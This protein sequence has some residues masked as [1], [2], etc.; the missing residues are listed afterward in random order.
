MIR[1]KQAGRTGLFFLFI[2]VS[3]A[4]GQT[5]ILSDSLSWV[6]TGGPPGGLGY[7]IRYNYNDISI[8]YVTDAF[9]GVSI[10]T[11]RGTTWQPANTGIQAELGPTGDWIPIF[12]LTVD[13]LDPQ[14]VWAGTQWTG[15]IYKSIDGGYTWT[16]KDNGV[17]ILYDK[18]SFRG[19]TIDPRSSDIVYA[20]G[21]TTRN[22]P[23]PDE[24]GGQI[25]KTTDGGETW[26]LIWDGG[27]PSA[28][29][30]YLWTD[31]R[32]PDRLYV[33]TGIFDRPA[34]PN[35]TIPDLYDGLGVLKS[36]DG[37]M[38]WSAL[39]TANGLEMLHIGSLAMHPE[40]PDTL[41]AAA[42]HLLLSPATEYV[43]QQGYS[44]AGIYRTADGGDNWTRVLEPPLSRPNEAFSAVEYS[45][46]YP[47]IVYAGSEKAVYRS[48]DSGE[49]WELVSGGD[50][51]WG[52]PGV[53]ANWPIDFQCDPEDPYRLFANNYLGGNFL[54]TDGGQSWVNASQ[55]YTGAILMDVAV[56]PENPARVY[57]VGRT[58]IWRSDRSGDAWYGLRYGDGER[59][60]ASEWY[61]IE[62]DPSDPSHILAGGKNGIILLESFDGGM[63][64]DYRWSMFDMWPPEVVL[65]E[66]EN[67][68]PTTIVFA[69]SN[70][71]IVYA[72]GA[73]Q[74]SAQLHENAIIPAVG[75]LISQDGGHTWQVCSND[76][77]NDLAVFDLA[78]D[79][80]D[81]AA[82]YMAAEDGLYMT[83]DGG[84][85]WSHLQ[86]LQY[87]GM[88]RAVEV[89]P[90]D[91][92]H[93]L[94]AL[95]GFG[96]YVSTDGGQQ[97]QS[98]VAGLEPN[99]SIHDIVF[100]PTNPVIVYV[101]DYF[102][103]V[104]RSNDGG[105][106][107]TQM[108]NGLSTRSV[109][110]LAISGD[111]QHLYTATNGGGV[112]RLDLSGVAPT[113][114]ISSSQPPPHFELNQNYPNPFNAQTT[115]F[116]RIRSRSRVVIRIYDILGRRVETLVEKIEEPGRHTV[117]WNAGD[118]PS[119][120]YLCR[121]EAGD[122]SKTIRLLM[123][124]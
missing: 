52:P 85:S 96:V 42:G 49:T 77:V 114:V 56:D 92:D 95:E 6:R 12:C 18:L 22:D 20:M 23:N 14:I 5:T 124:K 35:D 1:M 115:I 60:A 80:T 38:T 11:D 82:V 19:F 4:I 93:I 99:G 116:Y 94:A 75:L 63:N 91:A 9:S 81:A 51:G 87:G 27:M 47:N 43:L 71:S 107:W 32:D 102:S 67:M 66:T 26:K 109:T 57:A 120:V 113:N 24:T 98:G 106:S 50:D 72:G 13:P 103:G 46:S 59:I 44:P 21:E 76:S 84:I 17:S 37:G 100:D 10:S 64:W 78:V 117:V 83:P 111:G 54:S 28:L 86:I 53:L 110:G 104:Y 45:T 69:P 65:Q 74:S 8:W 29:T 122:Y 121:L 16:E 48:E 62:T 15:R 118:L 2:M 7:D 58:G 55:G 70:P 36:T 101:S 33:S 90:F 61:A 97:W 108:N 40:H 34:V 30:R 119:G 89:S 79:P 105:M 41:L 123:M 3:P 39:D 112:F 88:V 73:N 25:Y 68:M 31:P